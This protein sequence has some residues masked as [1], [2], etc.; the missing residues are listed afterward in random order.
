VGGWRQ[1]MLEITAEVGNGWIPWN[2][3]VD[4]YAKRMTWI[5]ERAKELGRAG[6]ISY[7]AGLIVLPETEADATMSQAHSKQ[8]ALTTKTI[9]EWSDRFED[10]GCEVLF[11]M[12]LPDPRDANAVLYQV[13]EELM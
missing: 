2:R 5:R 10:V 6:D 4:S 1:N 9:R 3:T 8:P 7:G 12:V 13:A 11:L